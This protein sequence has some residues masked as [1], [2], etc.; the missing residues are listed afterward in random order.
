VKKAILVSIIFCLILGAGKMALREPCVSGKFY[1]GDA[2]KLKKTVEIYLDE[3]VEKKGGKPRGLI[4]P[5]AG[6]P[7]SAQIAADAFKRVQGFSYDF[8]IILGTNHTVYPENC[9]FLYDGDGFKTSLG[10]VIVDKK[11]TEQLIKKGD[12]FKFNNNAHSREHSIEVQLPFIQIILPKVNI[13]P[14]V[15]A[16]SDKNYC[17]K[18]GKAIAEIVK[19]KNFLIIASSDLSHYP[20]YDVAEVVDRE[21]LKSLATMD[22][23]KIAEVETNNLRKPNVDTTACGIGGIMCLIETMSNLNCKKVTVISYANSGH[24]VIGEQ[25][26]VVGYGAVEFEEGAYQSD[27]SALEIP[28]YGDE[29]NQMEK[30]YL[31]KLARRTLED[32]LN[33]KVFTLPRFISR[34]LQKKQGAFVTLN[35]K[36]DLRGCIGHMAE[37]TPL[38]TTVSMMALSAALEDRRFYPVDKSELKDIE[39]EISVLTPMKEVSGFKEIVIGRDGT[40]IQ[41]KERSAVFLPQVAPEQGWSREEMLENLCLKAGLSP[42]DWK[43]GCKFFT[44]QAIVFSEKKH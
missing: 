19:D 14:I 31:L 23:N 35:K 21:T 36:G 22:L 16:T 39:I 33:Y 32:Y 27:T 3:A 5:H 20:N 43:S 10:T 29:L 28:S 2:E 26:R 12:L 40:L 8:V 9:G 37:D 7:F 4:V 13:V 6:Y 15:I 42:D 25:D 41:K 34:N 11:I 24:T 18:I 1:D 17:Q 38:A 30:E 44:F